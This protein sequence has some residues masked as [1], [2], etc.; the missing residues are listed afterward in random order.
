MQNLRTF[1]LLM[2]AL[3]MVGLLAGANALSARAAQDDPTT[4]LVRVA[5]LAPFA[6][7]PDTAVTVELNGIE[8]QTNFQFGDSTTYVEVPADSYD[9]DV[10]VG[11]SETAALSDTIVVEAG[12]VYSVAAIGDGTNQA[13]ALLAVEDDNTAPAAGQFHLRL[14]HLAPF[15]A[16]NATADVRLQDGTVVADDVNFSDVTGYIPLPAGEYDLKITTPDGAT[17]L[18]D[19]LPATFAE[20]DIVTA[21]ATGDGTNQPLGAFAWPVDVEGFF[22]PL[23]TDP[24][25]LRV[26]HLA[27]FAMDPDTSVTVSLNGSPALTDF[28][29]GDSTP[30][31]ELDPGDYLV[32]V[33]PGGGATAAISETVTL[34]PATYYSAAAVGDGVNQPLGLVAVMDDNTAPA[35]G[36]FH[37]RLG[38]LAPFAA[39][40]ATADVR[41]QDGTVVAD[42]VNFGDVTGYI[43]LPA[44]EY[45]LK[46][47][48]PDG[49]T[50]LI[51]PLPATFAEGDIVTAFATGDGANQPLGAFAW[52]VDVEGFFLPL[53]TDTDM[54]YIYMPVVTAP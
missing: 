51:D 40:M 9:V 10:F 43:P 54:V 38:H 27:P 12:K 2:T 39:G 44:G 53:A 5:H 28:A 22:L 25:Y 20:G 17:T 33:F 32:E 4:A 35:A 36:E 1:R 15:A 30:Y 48:T 16:G 37:L 34:A 50:T 14:G 13:L 31:I 47:T 11:D 18:I 46:I 7:D 8:F 3:V 45:D 29:Y 19:P 26:A 6:M 42:D 41:L 21:F 49:A 23:A 52:P 24:A